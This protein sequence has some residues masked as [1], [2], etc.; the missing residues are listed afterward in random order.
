MVLSSSAL[1]VDWTIQTVILSV[2]WS[3]TNTEN[4][5]TVVEIYGV[6]IKSTF[7]TVDVIFSQHN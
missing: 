4:D 3:G 1:T 5:N 7:S 2:V 6:L